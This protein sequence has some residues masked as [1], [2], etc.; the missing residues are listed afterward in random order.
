MGSPGARCGTT[1]ANLG[2]LQPP[3]CFPDLRSFFSPRE[4]TIDSGIVLVEPERM[5]PAVSGVLGRYAI[6]QVRT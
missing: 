6:S 2:E 4:N 5:V 3:N 1:V